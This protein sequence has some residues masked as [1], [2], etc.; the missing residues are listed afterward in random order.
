M[1]LCDT[2]PMVALINARDSEHARC[3]AAL[4][5]LSKPLRTTWPC[6]T[7]AMHLLWRFG[8]F[9]AQN[10]LWGY[11]EDGLVTTPPHH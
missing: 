9:P 10:E 11:L 3:V 1:T 5:Q 2:G 6:V 7:E 8:G 4:S